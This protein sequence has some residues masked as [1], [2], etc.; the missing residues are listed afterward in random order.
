MQTVLVPVV[1]E[2][3]R[4]LHTSSAN[5]SWALT[6][7][8]IAAAVTVPV[9]GRLGDMFGKRRML[10]ITLA[11]L[12]LGC[13]VCGFTSSLPLFLVGR[14]L[15]GCG[16]STIPLGISMLRDELPRARVP[17]AIALVSATLGAGGSLGLPISAWMAAA[18]SWHLMFGVVA[19]RYLSSQVRHRVLSSF[20]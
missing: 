1:G 17:G 19:V 13:V 12:A 8:L 5:G 3:G 20:G 18:Y 9:I 10:V 15:Q 6:S 16:M 4:L 14:A 2:L 11:L 7:T